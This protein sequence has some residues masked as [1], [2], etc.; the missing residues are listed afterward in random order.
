MR[1][2]GIAAPDDAGLPAGEDEHL[3]VVDFIAMAWSRAVVGAAP[4]SPGLLSSFADLELERTRLRRV[5]TPP[6]GA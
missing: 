2:S 5:F 4:P 6:E 3:A 1:V